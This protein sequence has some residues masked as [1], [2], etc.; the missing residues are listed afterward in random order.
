MYQTMIHLKMG[1]ELITK[2][3]ILFV[4][5]LRNKPSTQ[6]EIIDYITTRDEEIGPIDRNMFERDKRT[7]KNVWNVEINYK[8][9]KYEIIDSYNDNDS[10]KRLISSYELI[11]ALNRPHTLHQNLY[12]Q[13]TATNQTKYFDDIL[14]AIDHKNVIEFQLDSYERGKSKRKC[15]P[16]AIKEANHRWYLIGYDIDKKAFRNYGLDRVNSLRNI[17]E[18]CTPPPFNVDEKFAQTIGIEYDKEVKEII[19]Q[20]DLSQKKYIENLPIHTSQEIKNCTDTT[21]DVHLFLQPTYELKMKILE[22]SEHCEVLAP[23]TLRA[24]LKMTVEK[25]YKKYTTQNK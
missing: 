16:V 13:R 3:Q 18:K 20:F 6:K 22:Y 23:A 5:A 1:Q 2:R 24:E 19:L 8:A 12:L 11:Y 14:N 21:F 4:K 17:D 25:L 10:I 9:G 15:A 7:I